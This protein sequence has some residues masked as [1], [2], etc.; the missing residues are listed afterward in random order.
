MMPVSFVAPVEI[1]F[2]PYV[3]ERSDLPPSEHPGVPNTQ[4]LKEKTPQAEKYQKSIAEQNS[5]HQAWNLLMED[6]FADLRATIYSTPDELRRFRQMVINVVLATGKFFM[7]SCSVVCHASLTLICLF[8]GCS[9]GVTQTSA[10]RSLEHF[11]RP[12]GPRPSR[13]NQSTSPRKMTLIARL[14]LS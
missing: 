10:I 13:T 3:A 4:L 7:C 8:C 6:Q 1:A 14:R 11:V 2:F 12:A 9:P 5:I